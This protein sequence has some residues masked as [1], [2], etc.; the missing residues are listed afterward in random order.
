MKLGIITDGISRELEHAL[1]VMN[2]TGIENA[3]FQYIW[4]KEVGDL[5]DSQIT[6]VQSLVKAHEVNVSCIS[7][8]ILGGLSLGSIEKD[9]PA[10]ISHIGALKRCIQMAKALDCPLVRV[11]SFAKEM[12]LFGSHGAEA[13]NVSTGAWDKFIK[14]MEIPVQI[15]EDEGITLVVET[16]NN[17]MITSAWLARKLM[18]ALG[19]ERLRLLWDPANSLYCNET[20]FPDGYDAVKG[21]YIG[22]IHIKDAI[23]DIPKATLTNTEFNKGQMAPYLKDIA[24][25]LKQEEYSGG[26]SFESVYRPIGGSFEDGFRASLNAFKEIFGA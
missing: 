12:I 13:W 14:L 3:E 24:K 11:M 23:V 22:H 17:A 8:H 5:T 9:S 2:E 15:A 16:G 7:R 1:A 18:D 19:T 6:K 4:D 25:A 20:P 10:F 21:G 26:I